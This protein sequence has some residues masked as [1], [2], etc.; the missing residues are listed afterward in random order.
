MTPHRLTPRTHCQSRSVWVQIGPSTATPALLCTTCT[1]PNEDN[2][3][4]ASASTDS[5]TETS[6]QTPTTEWPA[7]ESSDSVLS[8]ASCWTSAMTTRM[9]CSAKRVATARPMP[10]APPVTTATFPSRFFID[11]SSRSCSFSWSLSA[12]RERRL[13][14]LRVGGDAFTG[15]V[16]GEQPHLFGEFVVGG[17]PKMVQPIARKGRLDGLDGQGS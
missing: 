1:A 10:L 12:R 17:C 2:A 7:A 13:S 8:S 6:V 9:P 11:M 15:V 14:A 16:R 4:A 3:A 5:A